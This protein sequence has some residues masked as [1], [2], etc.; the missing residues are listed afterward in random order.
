MAKTKRRKPKTSRIRKQINIGYRKEICD[1][2]IRTFGSSV[3][4]RTLSI[5]H[6]RDPKELLTDHQDLEPLIKRNRTNKPYSAR[7]TRWLDRLAH[8]DINTK[9]I[10]GTHLA[11]TI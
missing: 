6:I 7:L 11:L 8:F 3:G 10:T 5:I 9:H 2:R 4:I 1:K